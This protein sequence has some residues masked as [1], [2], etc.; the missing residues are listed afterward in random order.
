MR[1]ECQ[2]AWLSLNT[3]NV[4]NLFLKQ[5]AEQQKTPLAGA[6]HAG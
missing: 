2:Q 5:Y 3:M 6:V 1:V 4:Q